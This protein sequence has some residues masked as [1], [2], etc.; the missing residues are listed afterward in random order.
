MKQNTEF[1]TSVAREETGH[2]PG[3]W[4]DC[5]QNKDGSVVRIF[6]KCQY[7]GSIGMGEGCSTAD[8][9]KANASLIAAAPDLLDSLQ[10]VIQWIDSWDPNFANDEEWPGANSRAKAAI[11][12]ARG[13]SP[14]TAPST[15]AG[16]QE[17]K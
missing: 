5:S 7:I 11:A 14:D 13:L 2:T 12:K 9:T 17:K 8:Q 3:P 10:E 16:F 4:D 6:A 15:P 1:T